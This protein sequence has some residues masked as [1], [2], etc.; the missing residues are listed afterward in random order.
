MDGELEEKTP[1]H[2]PQRPGSTMQEK[3]GLR[4]NHPMTWW[5]SEKRERSPDV[6]LVAS[7]SCS[8]KREISAA[9]RRLLP[10]PS[11]DVLTPTL[12][13]GLALRMAPVEDSLAQNLAYF[14]IVSSHPQVG[15]PRHRPPLGRTISVRRTSD[16]DVECCRWLS[17]D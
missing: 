11:G 12:Q 1:A 2:A 3:K 6:S 5:Q 7:G 15:S 9:A 8:N 4:I 10:P 16:D 13:A 17:P 14:L